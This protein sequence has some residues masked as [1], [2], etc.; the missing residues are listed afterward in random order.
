MKRSKLA[1]PEKLNQ[2]YNYL[3]SVEKVINRTHVLITDEPEVLRDGQDGEQNMG[4]DEK[5]KEVIGV[6]RLEDPERQKL[7]SHIEATRG[8][9]VR[10][11]P[12]GMKRARENETA[13]AGCVGS[14]TTVLCVEDLLNQPQSETENFAMD[15]RVACLLPQ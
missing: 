2:D 11:A 13:I 7:A 1:S 5:G 10:Q 4:E 6:G 9:T 3:I 8:V 12:R 14:T 15:R